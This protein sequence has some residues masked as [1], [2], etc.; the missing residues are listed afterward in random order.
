MKDEISHTL[1][2]SEIN[3]LLNSPLLEN[4]ITLG[5]LQKK[6]GITIN[7]IHNPK[8]RDE[9]KKTEIDLNRQIQLG[10]GIHISG[11]SKDV[12]RFLDFALG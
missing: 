7:H 5:D 2:E 8:I 12:F 6:F 11:N 10:M 4:G 3:V 9:S 1:M